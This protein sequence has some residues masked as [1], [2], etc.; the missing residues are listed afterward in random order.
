MTQTTAVQ[1]PTA[2]RHETVTDLHGHR[3]A[4]D[5]SWLREK[6]SPEVIAYLEQE[7]AYTSAVMK[8]TDELQRKLYQEMISHIKETD[9]SVPFPDGEYF[10]YSRTEQG[11]QYPIY[12]RKKGSIESEEQ[13]ILDM[14]ELAAG[15]EFMAL[16]AFTVSDNGE[17]L[18][19]ST[20][21]TGFRQYTLHIKRL[22]TGEVLADQAERVGYIVWTSDKQTLF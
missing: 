19:Y 20:D 12:C 14:N 10:Y 18:A 3:L 4:D 21:T 11:A 7:N 2:R 16:G 6:T 13:I 15:Q 5:Y 1:P 17:L 9:I 8:P 22:A